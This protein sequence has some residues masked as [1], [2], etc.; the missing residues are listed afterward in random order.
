MQLRP[1]LEHFTHL[2]GPVTL[3][4]V[5]PSGVSP[6]TGT[7]NIEPPKSDRDLKQWVSGWHLVRGGGRRGR[8]NEP[9]FSF[10]IRRT[11]ADQ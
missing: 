9:P 10:L 2:H 4:S 8:M 7:I 6:R 1:L 3:I 5:S 11:L